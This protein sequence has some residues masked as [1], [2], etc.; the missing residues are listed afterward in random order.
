[1]CDP[2]P[3]LSLINNCSAVL[4]AFG[5]QETRENQLKRRRNNRTINNKPNTKGHLS[6]ISQDKPNMSSNTHLKTTEPSLN[7]QTTMMLQNPS[8][9]N[10]NNL[11]KSLYIA[12]RSNTNSEDQL[13][14]LNNILSITN[15]MHSYISSLN[16]Q[17]HSL[18]QNKDG[19]ANSESRVLTSRVIGRKLWQAH[20]VFEKIFINYINNNK[21]QT[22]NKINSSSIYSKVNNNFVTNNYNQKTNKNSLI[23]SGTNNK[24]I[25]KNDSMNQK[26]SSLNLTSQ[27]Q[28]VMILP[29]VSQSQIRTT[30][31]IQPPPIK[32]ICIQPLHDADV[33]VI[34]DEEDE[35]EKK[36]HKTVTE[37]SMPLLN[38]TV[39]NKCIVGAGENL[40]NIAY[41]NITNVGKNMDALQNRRNIKSG[42]NQLLA[43][44]LSPPKDDTNTLLHKKPLN[45]LEASSS[46]GFDNKKDKL[47]DN[48]LNNKS[49]KNTNGSNDTIPLNEDDK[50]NDEDCN[51]ASHKDNKNTSNKDNHTKSKDNDTNRKNNDS[52]SIDTRNNNKT[53]MKSNIEKKN[54]KVGKRKRKSDAFGEVRR[55]SRRLSAKT[56]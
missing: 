20:H 9:F 53:K 24:L 19:S 56:P 42:N 55:S 15:T 38:T 32:P 51:N 37:V 33:C 14:M 6:L 54:D 31:L 48:N 39:N 27:S 26:V 1:M 52:N 18:N 35:Y 30:T 41:K 2:T 4:E 23:I 29:K 36:V 28:F 45:N 44:N 46:N 25:Q 5:K 12:N 22:S 17:L 13:L 10:I 49:N 34:S 3:L 7:E 47:C 11:S 16:K 43:S 40:I 8:I 50:I 21:P